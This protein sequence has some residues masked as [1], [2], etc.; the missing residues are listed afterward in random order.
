MN[1]CELIR[2]DIREEFVFEFIC[3][4]VNECE[5][6]WIYLIGCAAVQQCG[7]AVCGIVRGCLWQC[8]RQC[9]AVCGSV[10]QSAHQCVVARSLRIYTQS[11]SQIYLLVWPYKGGENEPHVRRKSFQTDQYEL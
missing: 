10:W 4:K 8:T 5:F 7:A 9:A 6:I 11:R 2:I 3:I 1:L